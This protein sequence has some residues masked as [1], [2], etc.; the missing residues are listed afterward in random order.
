MVF[1]ETEFYIIGLLKRFIMMPYIVNFS[2]NGNEFIFN[3]PIVMS[4]LKLFRIIIFL[5]LIEHHL[6]YIQK[7]DRKYQCWNLRL[8]QAHN[9]ECA[10]IR[11]LLVN[12]MG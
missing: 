11:W 6:T 4:D 10:W 8:R 5:V 7:Q 12:E 1:Y 3:I 2:N 9:V